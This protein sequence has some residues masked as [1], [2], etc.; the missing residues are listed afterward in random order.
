MR[1]VVQRVRQAE[2]VVGDELVGRIGRGL[3]VLAGLGRG[4]GE[5]EVGW[6][7]RK[8]AAL[9]VFDDPGSQAGRSVVEAGGEVLAISQFTL[10]ADCRK[11]RRPSYDHAM[12]ATHATALFDRFV[13][14]LRVAAGAVAT[15]RFGADMQVRLVNDGPFT[16]VI[17]SASERVSSQSKI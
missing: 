6:M 15:G 2:V 9:R 4:D 12:P 5:D 1:A 7:A 17:D 10:L 16:L 13:A 8:I 11:G 14:A 3:V